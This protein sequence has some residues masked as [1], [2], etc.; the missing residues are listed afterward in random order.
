MPR[1][2]AEM[3][4]PEGDY[5]EIVGDEIVGASPPHGMARQQNYGSPF[6]GVRPQVPRAKRRTAIPVDSGSNVNNA[7]STTIEIEP[8]EDFRPERLIAP[9]GWFI[10]SLT[11]GSE[12]Q[13]VTDGSLPSDMFAANATDAQLTYRTCGRGQKIVVGVTNN[14]GNA[15]RFVGG[16][17][18]STVLRN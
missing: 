2:L 11:I 6:S 14:T 9:V 8:Q 10:D 5:S 3:L 16:F 18:G 7:A 15:A 12:N 17:Y 13:F 4:Y 1:R